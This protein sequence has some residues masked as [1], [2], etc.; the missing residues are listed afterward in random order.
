MNLKE[1]ISEDLKTA[2][3][4]GDKLR[5]ETIRTICA[6]IIE[7]EKRG[8]NREL[9]EDDVTQ[10]LLANAK[11][12][13]EAIEMFEKGGRPDLVEKESKELE[14]IREYLPKQLSNEEIES[15][16]KEIV[17]QIGATSAKD[18]GKV[19]GIAIKKMKGTADGKLIQ[20]IVK[21]LL[22]S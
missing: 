16:L 15:R 6:G 8:L 22:G 3:K 20:E 17:A 14:I 9:T 13:K 7:F 10:V 5:L 1:K 2:M 4:S 19:M 18:L 11:K 21:R 12:R